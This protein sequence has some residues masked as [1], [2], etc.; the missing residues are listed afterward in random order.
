M[1]EHTRQPGGDLLAAGRWSR[2][3]A[4]P[5]VCAVA[6]AL[7]LVALV[8]V[9]NA[10]GGGAS[11]I[12]VT[13]AWAR[14]AQP[15]GDRRGDDPAA[16]AAMVGGNNSVAYLTI[17]NRGDGRDTLIGATA[18]GFGAVELHQSTIVDNVASMRRV[19]EVVVPGRG[20]VHF[21]P[22]GYHLVLVGATRA[23]RPGDV[24]E[25]D[26]MFERLGAV[27]VAAQVREP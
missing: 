20:A 3:V 19:R 4:V 14:P 16:A 17:E 27:G 13:D 12:V 10:R 25:I 5:L 24:V 8:G 6:L 7:A 18:A 2:R 23:F 9:I 15:T 11:D 26:L 22:G 1:P 21:S